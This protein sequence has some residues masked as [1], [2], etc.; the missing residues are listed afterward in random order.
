MVKLTLEYDGTRYV[1]WQVQPNGPSIQSEVER[2]LATLHKGFRRITG[3][4]R[5][6]AGVHARGQVASC[7]VERPLPLDAYVKGMNALLPGDIAVRAATIEP[8]G[9]DARRSALGK[10][11]R[12]AIGQSPTR[13]PLSRL[14]AW[15][16]FRPLELSAMRAAAAPL[17]GRHDF[18]AFQAS[19]CA[20]D[21]AVRDLTRLD[22]LAVEGERVEVVVEAT[23]FVKHM[24]RNIVGTLVE[25]GQGRRDP[26]SIPALLAG[27]DRTRAGRTAPAHGLTLE[28]VFYPLQG[29][30]ERAMDDPAA[31]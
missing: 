30:P 26:A 5:T 23:A 29:D 1:G 6:D 8:D 15:Q 3:A 25:C 28:Q 27:G 18:A 20:C 17:V 21:H 13:A 24:V 10:R 22:V 7:P 16:L 12:Y 4:G 9:F 2:A 19:D 14:Y 11:Y 31:T